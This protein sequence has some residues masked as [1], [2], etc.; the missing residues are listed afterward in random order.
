MCPRELVQRLDEVAVRSER[1]R[2]WIVRHRSPIGW[3]KLNGATSSPATRCKILPKTAP[4]PI[5]TCWK[6]SSSA[7]VGVAPPG[8]HRPNPAWL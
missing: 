4:S 7:S 2:S 8:D 3:W 1:S 6:R 5:E